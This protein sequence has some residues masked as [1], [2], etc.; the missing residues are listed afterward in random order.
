MGASFL[1][2]G[3]CLEAM[4]LS[5][6]FQVSSFNASKVLGFLESVPAPHL[7]TRA[8]PPELQPHQPR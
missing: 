7:N 4:E 8:R 3:A 6:K 5:G 2:V 1:A